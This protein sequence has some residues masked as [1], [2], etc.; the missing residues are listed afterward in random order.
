[1]IGLGAGCCTALATEMCSKV[2]GDTSRKHIH[3][4]EIEAKRSGSTSP[5][6]EMVKQGSAKCV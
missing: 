4:I 5:S 6:L 3:L 1:M 2:L